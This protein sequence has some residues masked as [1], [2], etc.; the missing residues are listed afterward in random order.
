MNIIKSVKFWL[1]A[2][3]FSMGMVLTGCDLL[4]GDDEDEN[5]A[6]TIENAA[7]ATS[8]VVV[9]VTYSLTGVVKD[10][11]GIASITITVTDAAG[12]A[13]T[14]TPIAG[15][16]AQTTWDLG[17]NSQTFVV[18][19]TAQAGAATLDIVATD[20]AGLT[21]TA[22]VPLTVSTGV[23]L[24]PATLTAGSS[25]HATLGSSIDLDADAVLLAADAAAAISEVDLVYLTEGGVDGFYSP[26]HAATVV[27]WSSWSSLTPPTISFIKTDLDAAGFNAVVNEEQIAELWAAGT[28]TTTTLSVAQGDVF[29]VQTT[30]SLLALVLINTQVPGA[31][32]T[33][34]IKTAM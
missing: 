32:G 23:P 11:A 8:P 5:A 25:G 34:S 2:I 30:E 21:V 33:I 17:A 3:M 13:S 20:D 22:S 31:S 9:G 26:S 14:I 12:T 18:P 27:T 29:V 19:V 28:P 16:A 10:D 24:V 6:P 7:V 1:I 4:G 15:F